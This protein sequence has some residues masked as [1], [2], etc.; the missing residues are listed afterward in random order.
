MLDH[1]NG[2][3]AELRAVGVPVSLTES[4]DAVQALQHIRIEDRETFKHTLAATLVKDQSHRQAFETLFKVYFALSGSGPQYEIVAADGVEADTNAADSGQTDDADDD[5][6]NTGRTGRD[7]SDHRNGGRTS[8]LS[9]EDLAEMLYRA[10]LDN[11]REMMAFAARQAVLR[12]AGMEPGRPVSGVYYLYRTLRSLDLDGVLERLL[13]HDQNTEG[14]APSDLDSFTGRLRRDEYQFRI[15][16]LKD[17]IE[18][19]IR[20]RLVADRGARAMS[21]TL[22]KP[23]PSDIEFMHASR[24]EIAGLR[25]AV[26]PLARKL[27][28]RLAR[29]RRRGRRGPLDFRSTVRHSLSCGGVL[30]EPKFRSP[31][32]HKPEIMVVADVSG[33]VAAFARFTLHIVYAISSQFAKVRSFV[34]IDGLDEV[35][36]F[37][38]SA[39]DV[40]EAV[41]RVDAQADVVWLDG[42]S[43]YGHALGVFWDRYADGIGPRTTVMI[44]GDARNNY[45]AAQS[46]VVQGM[47]RKARRVYWLNPEPRSY[48]NTG[49]SIVGE[50]EPWCD[51]V[52]EVRNLRQLEAF[53]DCLA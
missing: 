9:S 5:S 6:G 2:F 22:R 53:I 20:R 42:H 34:F 48:W 28:V 29:K 7:A 49:D 32:P 30:A 44:L 1:L 52:F 15:A 25:R 27:A 40:G 31:R 39:A 13:Q 47:Q 38:E 45:H 24:D 37:F 23:L 8:V 35:T 33:S 12:H 43:D 19:D 41:R 11:D 14:D 3:I 10:L 4:I 36:R 21:K 51:G 26:H 46:W 17:E 18:D 50:Y 16:E